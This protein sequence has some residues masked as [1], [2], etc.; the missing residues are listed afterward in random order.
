V[1][2]EIL[3]DQTSGADIVAKAKEVHAASQNTALLAAAISEVSGGSISVS[4]NSVSVAQAPTLNALFET[5][6]VVYTGN[7]ASTFTSSSVRDAVGTG[8]GGTVTSVVAATT[9]TTVTRNQ[10]VYV[11]NNYKWRLG[12]TATSLAW[13]HR[14]CIWPVSILMFALYNS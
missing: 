1:A 2:G 8:I 3:V 4:S 11:P 14:V 12:N 10:E 5:S 7:E 9:T 6:V 13:G